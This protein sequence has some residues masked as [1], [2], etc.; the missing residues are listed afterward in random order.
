MAGCRPEYLPVVLAAVE[1]ACTSSFNA[2][3]LLATT[4]FSGPVLVVNGPIATDIGMNSGVNVFGQGNRANTTIGRALQLVIRN[5]GGGLPNGVDRATF[6]NPGKVGF[7]FAENEA[8][9]WGSLAA[10][11]GAAPGTSSVTLF[12]GEG[13]RAIV[14]QKSRTA[15]SL[16]RSFAAC[17]RTVGHPKLPVGFDAMLCVSPEHLRTFAS[18]GWDRQR[19]RGELLSHLQLPGTEIIRGAGGIDEGVPA[20]FSAHTLPKFRPGGLLLVHCGGDAGMFSAIIGGW[21]SG[22]EGSEPA[23]VDI[24][25]WR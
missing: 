16:A 25:P 1:A 18:E 14:D 21:V 5:V 24:E 22:A 15:D 10:D 3:G 4:Y 6:G 2:H 9:G 19:L 7:C 13:P 11:R 17:L 23:T 12:A 8:A 20:D